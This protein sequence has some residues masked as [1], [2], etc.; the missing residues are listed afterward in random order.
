MR[1]SAQTT[2]AKPPP[3]TAK[4]NKQTHRKIILRPHTVRKDTCSKLPR[5]T[6][7]HRQRIPFHC[8]SFGFAKIRFPPEIQTMRCATDTQEALGYC[9]PSIG[10]SH[11][12]HLL[13]STVLK[14][15]SK[16]FLHI[17]QI[18]CLCFSKH[19]LQHRPQNDCRFGYMQH[20]DPR[21]GH[22]QL[23][24][25]ACTR[26]RVKSVTGPAWWT[27]LRSPW[28]RWRSGQKSHTTI[29]LRWNATTCC[30]QIEII[31]TS[32]NAYAVSNRSVWSSYFYI[33]ESLMS[34][35]CG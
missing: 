22:H 5:S 8:N 15:L 10:Q 13:S 30:T 25:R 16:T 12:R 24:M 32:W 11:T 31:F 3:E 2:L 29:K 1:H 17:S 26:S 20:S 18:R 34:Y 33:L 4:W 7:G 19:F 23:P 14:L 35:M 21:P 9:K 6:T 27:Y 28:Q